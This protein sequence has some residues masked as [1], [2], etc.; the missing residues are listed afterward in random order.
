[1]TSQP[2]DENDDEWYCRARILCLPS[3]MYVVCIIKPING[4]K[5]LYIVSGQ[6]NLNSLSANQMGPMRHNGVKFAPA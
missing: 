2:I 1:M 6:G 4:R 3:T 5:K